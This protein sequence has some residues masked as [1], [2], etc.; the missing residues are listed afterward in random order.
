MMPLSSVTMKAALPLVSR[1]SFS[2]RWALRWASITLLAQPQPVQT[3]KSTPASRKA[4]TGQVVYWRERS[5][6]TEML[7]VSS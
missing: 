5:F 4:V 1:A 2:A 6:S 3:G 7:V